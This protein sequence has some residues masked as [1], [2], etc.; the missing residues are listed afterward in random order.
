MCLFK[1]IPG[2]LSENPLAVNGLTSPKNSWYLQQS[3]F[4]LLLHHS[5][6]N[7]LKKKFFLIRSENLGLLYNMLTGNYEYC[8]SYRENFPL[9]IQIKLSKK[10]KIFCHTSF[11]FLVSTLNFQC[12]EKK[13]TLI[14]QV[15][16]KL[17]TPKDVVI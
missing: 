6:P 10:P 3:S 11:A 8:H 12:F 2:L 7:W 14:N 4:L 1:W 9:P 13:I 17:L 16:L 15:F 5:E